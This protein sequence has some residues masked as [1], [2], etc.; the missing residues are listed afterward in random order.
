MQTVL[1]LLVASIV[2]MSAVSLLVAFHSLTIGLQEDWP[3]QGYF[4][5]G[6]LILSSIVI[7]L[8]IIVI[9]NLVKKSL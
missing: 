7:P 3:W 9:H 6:I 8:G 5:F 2:G 4:G 1:V